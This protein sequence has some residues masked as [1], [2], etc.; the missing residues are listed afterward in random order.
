MEWDELR[1]II[2]RYS[3]SILCENPLIVMAGAHHGEICIDTFKKIFQK[4]K[5]FLFKQFLIHKK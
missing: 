1:D 2:W 4:H 5:Y 3:K